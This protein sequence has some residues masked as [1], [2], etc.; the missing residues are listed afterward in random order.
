[1]VDRNVNG[2]FTI[3]MFEVD[4]VGYSY[5]WYVFTLCIWSTEMVKVSSCIIQCPVFRAAQSTSLSPPGTYVH[6]DA[7]TSLGSIQTRGSD[8]TKPFVQVI[9][10]TVCSQVLVINEGPHTS[11]FPRH[12]PAT[13]K[14]NRQTTL[15]YSI[16][17]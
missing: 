16:R 10:T 15:L 8:C 1:M 13:C 14:I 6:S 12:I 2:N 11:S 9:F 4:T 17:P 7:F 5:H 3:Y